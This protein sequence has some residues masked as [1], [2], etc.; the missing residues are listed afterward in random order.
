MYAHA[1]AEHVAER[2]VLLLATPV[3]QVDAL[4]AALDLLRFEFAALERAQYVAEGR[5]LLLLVLLAA[6]LGRVVGQLLESVEHLR[7]LEWSQVDVSIATLQLEQESYRLA[8]N[9]AHVDITAPQKVQEMSHMP[10]EQQTTA[11]TATNY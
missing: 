2:V 4:H 7:L 5:A 3:V 8:G 9:N 1:V 6:M 11:A 10:V